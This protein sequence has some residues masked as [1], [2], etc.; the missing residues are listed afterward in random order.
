MANADLWT[1][2][3]GFVLAGP[4]SAA[5]HHLQTKGLALNAPDQGIGVHAFGDGSALVA[6]DGHPFPLP[7][8]RVEGVGNVPTQADRARIL[9]L[10]AAG[11]EPHDLWWAQVSTDSFSYGR[12]LHQ[13]VD[14]LAGYLAGKAKPFVDIQRIELVLEGA[15]PDVPGYAPSQDACL[16]GRIVVGS[17]GTPDRARGA[18][19]VLDSVCAGLNPFLFD[20]ANPPRSWRWVQR[21]ANDQDAAVWIR[22]T[23]FVFRMAM[24][25][26]R[27]PN[28][29]ETMALAAQLRA[30]TGL[31]I[32]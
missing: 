31:D 12:K 15:A 8:S 16:M 22:E 4:S 6:A 17:A 3:H 14:L 13:V 30:H 9:A 1:P 20:A 18:Q 27:I 19:A 7:L 25:L 23:P 29:H 2:P 26:E 28:A 10:H 24:S 11:W 5:F 32:L 21:S